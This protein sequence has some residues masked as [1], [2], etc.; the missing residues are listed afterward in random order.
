VSRPRD[1]RSRQGDV[2]AAQARAKPRAGG[3]STGRPEASKAFSAS[4]PPLGWRRS[5]QVQ[6]FANSSGPAPSFKFVAG[7]T[8]AK[9][10]TLAARSCLAAE[11]VRQGPRRAEQPAGGEAAQSGPSGTDHEAVARWSTAQ[12]NTLRQKWIRNV[13][14]CAGPTTPPVRVRSRQALPW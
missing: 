12:W 4:K 9:P 2:G 13:A 6:S 11:A 8:S 14:R 1:R 7:F 10:P 5:K 3:G